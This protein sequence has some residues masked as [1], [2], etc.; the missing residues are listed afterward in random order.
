MTRNN[1]V[2]RHLNRIKKRRDAR[3][4]GLSL[5]HKCRLNRRH[6]EVEKASAFITNLSDHELTDDEILALSKGLGFVPTPNKPKKSAI[7]KDCNA[8]IRTMRIRFIAATNRWPKTHKFRLPSKWNPGPTRNCKLEDFFENLKEEISK[9]PIKNA[10]FNYNSSMKKAWEDLKK[11]TNLILKG[12]DKGR[13]IAVISKE[14]YLQEGYRQL[15]KLIRIN[16]SNLTTILLRIQLTCYTVLSVKCI[17]V[18][19]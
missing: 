9:V 15:T 13:G 14:H 5:Q 3:K 17:F 10:K 16:I 11:N 19:S 8:F 18:S 7:M 4:D 2:K 12:Y 1:R 6:H